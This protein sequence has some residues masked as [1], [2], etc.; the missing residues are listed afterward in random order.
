MISFDVAGN[1]VGQGNHRIAR[2]GPFPR[3]YDSAKGLD[4][5]RALVSWTAKEFA[6]VTPIE[7]PIRLEVTFWLPLPKSA[8][9]RKRIYPIRKPDI[10]KLIRAVADA[11]TGVLYRDDSQI[12]EALVL[13]RYAYDRMTGA[14]VTVQQIEH[15]DVREYEGEVRQ[16]E[17]TR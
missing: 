13:K 1:P 15:H 9:K 6:P 7:G 3:L 8:P 2:G 17:R 10:D 11:L 14:S 12:V 16:W 4:A 5:W